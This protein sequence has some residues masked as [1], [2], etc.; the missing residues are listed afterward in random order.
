MLIDALSSAARRAGYAP[1][2]GPLAALPKS[3]K[4][5]PAMWIEPPKLAAVEGRKR[6]RLTYKVDFHLLALPAGKT[7]DQ[8]RKIR[9]QIDADAL[10]ICLELP[11][12]SEIILVRGVKAVPAPGSLTLSADLSAAVSM[13]AVIPFC[14]NQ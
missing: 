6:G 14:L 11:D 13:E 4:A 1:Y 8:T 2:S 7:P 9:Q 10:S 12:H 3:V 5:F